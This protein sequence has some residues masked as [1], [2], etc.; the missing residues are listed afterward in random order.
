MSP[1]PSRRGFTLIE[2]LVVI[3]II[4]ILIALLLPA[5]QKVREAAYRSQCAN[6]LKQIS[7][8][9]HNYES[10]NGYFPPGSSNWPS[11]ASSGGSMLSLVLPYM[12]QGNLY[13]HF[14]FGSDVN[15]S[16]TNWVARTQEVKSYLC[17]SDP[18]EGY[19]IQPGLPLGVGN[20]GRSN[21]LGNNG[22]TAHYLNPPAS[23]AALL[24]IFNI[25]TSFNA[26][27]QTNVV[28]TRVRFADVIDGTSNTCMLSETLRSTVGGGCG[29]HGTK[30][31]YN[32]TMIYLE[33]NSEFNWYTPQYG[34]PPYHC[35]S[36]DYG[37]TDGI[38]YRGCEYYRNIAE[39]VIYTHTVPPN[40]TGYDC[41]DYYITGAHI[42][43]RSAHPGGVNVA[44][45]DGS[46]RFI[47][48]S[49]ALDTWK[50]LGTRAGGEVVDEN[51]F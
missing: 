18:Q 16:D 11:G 27:T 43:A 41:G 19:L 24:G 33:P 26:A 28:T 47:R 22:A 21:Y 10:A 49:I 42:A 13:N 36:W 14:D 39:M 48:D 6:N 45:C 25:N 9:C 31:Y 34:S 30:D 38:L 29:P 2:L 40:Y 4:G 5:V 17:P 35:D 15:N 37:P 3:A 51:A 12:E 7:L 20:A 1:V 32:K 44:F 50:K 8:A 46:V 23:D